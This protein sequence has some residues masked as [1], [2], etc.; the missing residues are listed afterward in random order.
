MTKI[1][2]LKATVYTVKWGY[3]DNYWKPVLTIESGDFV[4]IEALNHQSGDAPDLL[5]DDAIKEIYDVVV[6]DM[7]DHIIT[8][9]IYVK[10]AEPNDIIEM[11]IIETKPRMNYGSNVL[12][13]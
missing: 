11:K 1:H 5:F 9:P 7:G 3:Y 4:D 8:G 12:A 10:D 13:N 6:R 2:E